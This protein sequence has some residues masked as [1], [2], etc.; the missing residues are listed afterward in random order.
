MTIR[1]LATTDPGA[2]GDQAGS[3]ASPR[4]ILCTGERME[5]LVTKLY[6]SYGLRTTDYE[7]KQS[8]SNEFYCYANFECEAWKWKG[9]PLAPS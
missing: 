6:R 7:V 3:S 9:E 2:D 4:L 5:A 8:V 1:W